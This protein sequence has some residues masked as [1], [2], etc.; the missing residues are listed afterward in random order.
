MKTPNSI[1]DLLL[2]NGSASL[3]DL[4]PLK[5]VKTE[6][7]K[8][9]LASQGYAPGFTIDEWPYAL[10]KEHIFY[11]KQLF[12]NT[13]YYDPD[14]AAIPIA[15]CLNIFCQDRMPIIDDENE[16]CEYILNF[17]ESLKNPNIDKVRSY[18]LAQ[19]DGF[20]SELL[21]EYIRRSDPSPELYSLFIDYYTVTDY[22]AGAYEVSLLQK[23]FSGRSEEQIAEIAEVLADYPD[24]VSIY[25]G[26]AEGSTPYHKA[27]SW[28]VD[29]NTA[30]FFACR[31]GDHDHARIFR[32]KV[33]KTDIMAAFLDRGEKEVIVLPG[34]P[35]EVSKEKLIG[36]SVINQFRYLKEYHEG[37][38]MITELYR[39]N[40][41]EIY[42][43]DKRHS[44]RVLFLA[45]MIIQTGKIRLSEVE[46]EQLRMAIVYHDIGRTNDAED[47]SHGVASRK[48]FEKHFSNPTVDF[49]I[50]YHCIDDKVADV[51]LTNSRTRLLYQIIEDADALDRVRFGLAHSD[52]NYLRLSI[53]H[54]LVPLAMAA[55]HGIKL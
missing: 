44:A 14:N 11:S 21:A 55:I 1:S 28:T 39:S 15:L 52:V 3:K 36:P 19:D 18:L 51:H 29:I 20:R 27:F 40:L 25:R 38:E 31:H 45:Y 5:K 41:H 7:D 2:R 43:H 33:R 24:V 9:N 35:F 10:T 13:Y 53:S 49:L 32:A 22:G 4:Y 37:R 42:D 47:I 30:F 16:F 17:A 50:Q 46:L 8:A 23:V 48:V 54:K 12:P 34:A 26:E 6:T